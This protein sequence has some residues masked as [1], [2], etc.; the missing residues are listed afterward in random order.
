MDGFGNGMAAILILS[1]II[2]AMLGIFGF[3]CNKV[4]DKFWNHDALIDEFFSETDENGNK[5]PF[6]DFL[7]P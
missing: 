6:T 4:I 1:A 3:I 7:L 5:L 2:G